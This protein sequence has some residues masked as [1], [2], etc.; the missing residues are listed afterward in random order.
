MKRFYILMVLF[1]PLLLVTAYLVWAT[2]FDGTQIGTDAKTLPA[3]G[4]ERVLSRYEKPHPVPDISFINGD[5][6]TLLLSDF[7]GK[8][9]LLNIWATWCFPCREEMPSLDRLQ[10]RL[11]GPDFE[12]VPLSTDR[13]GVEVIKAF[14]ADVGVKSLSIFADP[15]GKAASDL[16]ILGY[17]TTLL[18]DRNGQ[19]RGVKLGSAE[20]NNEEV[21]AL[22]Q[23]LI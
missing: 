15:T 23:E 13:A 1:I 12:V 3:P 2:F 5:G 17:P 22:I 9:V 10:A 8:V 19:A 16:K 14:Y 4:D 20:W 7:R 21:I 18:I 6:N 11:G